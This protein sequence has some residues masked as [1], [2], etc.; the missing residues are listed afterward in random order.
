[1]PVYQRERR[2]IAG[3][4]MNAAPPN[5]AV[6]VLAAGFSSRLGRPKALAR[7]RGVSLLRRTLLV[8][9]GTCAARIIV[10]LPRAAARLRIEGRGFRA[11]FAVNERR[12]EGLSSS[13][14]R[15]ILRARYSPAV[16]L[17]PVDLAALQRRDVIRLMSRWRGARRRVVAR[18]L[19]ERAGSAQGGAPLILPRWLYPRALAVSGDVG[20]RKL[21]SELSAAQRE[22]LNLSSAALDVDTPQDLRAARDRMHRS[23]I[24]P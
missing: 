11:L 18:R 13:V 6:L 1:M 20:L 19:G 16:L 9:S 8:I 21:V 23:R 14:R 2:F 4:R 24:T 12:A 17:V 3:V 22:L 5:P 15:G 7:V 10:V